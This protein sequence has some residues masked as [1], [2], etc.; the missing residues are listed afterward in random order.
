M[1]DLIP[2]VAAREMETVDDL[3]PSVTAREMETVG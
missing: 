1:D 3:I 2:P